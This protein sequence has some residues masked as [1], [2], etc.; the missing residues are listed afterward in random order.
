MKTFLRFSLFTLVLILFEAGFSFAQMNSSSNE[1]EKKFDSYLKP[2]DL[3]SRLEKLSAHPHHVGS[4]YDKENAEYILSLYKSW[5]WDAHIETFYVLFPTPKTRVLEMIAPQKFSPLLKEPVIKE[6]RT[7]GQGDEQIPTYNAYSI[8]G[9]VTGEIVYVN[10]GITSDYDQ[11]ER[12]GISVKG[13]IVIARYGGAWRGI[14]PKVAAEHGAIGC[15]IYS[16]PK[17]DGYYV[18][19]VYPKGSWRNEYGVQR[20]SV[21]DMPVYN[22]DPSTPFVGSTKDA[23][24][25]AVKDIKVL[26]K[27]PVMPISYHDALPML[28]SLTGPV[29]PGNWKGALPITYHVGPGETKV[30]L[31]LEF[32]WDI[33]PIRDIIA[34]MKGNRFPDQWVLRGNHHD[35][36]QSLCSLDSYRRCV[37]GVEYRADVAGNCRH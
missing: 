5:G 27:I 25:L 8:D 22:G 31:K 37:L 17:D 9:D 2:S 1:I 13:K 10:Y 32:N 34:V 3:K 14:K 11:L 24:H 36:V 15:I 12:M 4:P 33:K 6:D 20:G 18:G 30:H 28:K 26:T 19:D 29:V 21:V 23:K 35:G 7:S 16:D